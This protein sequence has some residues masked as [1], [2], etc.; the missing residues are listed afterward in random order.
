MVSHEI[1][2]PLNAVGGATALLGGTLLNEEQRELVALLEAGCSHVIC[3]I[4]DILLHGSLMNGA[5]TVAREPV[6]LSRA[7]LDPAWRMVAMQ[8]AV[9]AKLDSLRLSRSVAEDVPLE[10]YGDATRLTQVVVNLL[11]VRTCNPFACSASAP[12]SSLPGFRRA[13]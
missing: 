1:R 4:E 2:T 10:I 6:D 5:F 13:E 9:R 11:S 8:P 12:R 7:V 3:I